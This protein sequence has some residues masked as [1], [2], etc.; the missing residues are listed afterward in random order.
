MHLRAILLVDPASFVSSATRHACRVF[1]VGTRIADEHASIR[2]L[3]RGK[4][5]GIECRV[6]GKQPVQM[7]DV[8]RDR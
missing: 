1:D 4:R 5:A 7:E 2:H 8:R 6:S 3:D